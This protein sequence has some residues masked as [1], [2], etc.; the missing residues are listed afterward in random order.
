MICFDFDF[1]SPYIG[2]LAPTGAGSSSMVCGKFGSIPVLIFELFLFFSLL[3]V[4]TFF[5]VR[6]ELVKLSDEVGQGTS[7]DDNEPV[8]QTTN[9][10]SNK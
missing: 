10:K 1:C 2:K 8:T 6:D 9:K 5:L 7:E 4:V 3:L